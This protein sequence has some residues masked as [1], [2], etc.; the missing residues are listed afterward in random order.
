MNAMTKEEF[1]Q[2]LKK[3]VEECDGCDMHLRH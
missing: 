3:P 1:F 2:I